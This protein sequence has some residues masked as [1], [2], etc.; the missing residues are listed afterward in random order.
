MS[1]FANLY[2]SH[3]ILT[4]LVFFPGLAAI[5]C[6][7][8]PKERVREIALYAAVAEF[9]V[10]L[11]LFWTF[12]IGE[13]AFQNF[14]AIPWIPD[15]GISYSVGLDG[16]SLLLV[17]L[18]TFLLPI[19]VLVSWEQIHEKERAYYAMLL[20]LGTGM[21]GVFV[22]LDLFLGADVFPIPQ[23]EERR[24]HG[25]HSQRDRDHSPGPLSPTDR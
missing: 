4:F 19:S 3:W 1:L 25:D 21:L 11:P 16:I 2:S 23:R 24:R 20:F 14:V 10:S 9:L 13:I 8:A 5:V 15:W 22:A 6:L 7:F 12:V 18:T 17:L